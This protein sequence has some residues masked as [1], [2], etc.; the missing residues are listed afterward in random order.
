[1]GKYDTIYYLIL[2]YNP[3][4]LMIS[5]NTEPSNMWALLPIMKIYFYK[6][7]RLK[8]MDLFIYYISTHTIISQRQIIIPAKLPWVGLELLT[9]GVASRDGWLLDHR[10]RSMSIGQEKRFTSEAPHHHK[11]LD[12]PSPNL[13]TSLN[14]PLDLPSANIGHHPL[15]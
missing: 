12:L 8:G 3:S 10:W 15:T 5:Y 14:Q 7:C 2:Q 11:P 13:L 6:G 1:M 9:L 4:K